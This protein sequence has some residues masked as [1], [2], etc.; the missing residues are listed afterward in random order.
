MSKKLTAAGYDPTNIE[1][2]ARVLAKARGLMG[3]S[4]KRA[5]D[6][7]EDDDEDAW[8]EEGDDSMEVDGAEQTRAVKR[9]KKTSIVP[10][11]TRTPRTNRQLAG[12]GSTAE[13]VKATK[14]KD[15]DRR[16]PNRQAKVRSPVF[17]PIDLAL[18]SHATG[19][20]RRSPH[21]HQDAQVSL[22]RFVPYLSNISQHIADNFLQEKEET[23][24]PIDVNRCRPFLY[25]IRAHPPRPFSDLFSSFPVVLLPIYSRCTIIIPEHH[26]SLVVESDVFCCA[27]RRGRYSRPVRK[28]HD[29]VTKIRLQLCTRILVRQRTKHP[30]ISFFTSWLTRQSP[31]EQ[32]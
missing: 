18:T 23:E 29:M 21:F 27:R 14:L 26:S 16:E 25:C 9:A 2:R 6:D 13:A 28:F 22:C 1:E 10:R 17:F 20:R 19:W 7:M 24:R 5:V 32:Q 31:L 8:A 12:L 30:N 11:G 3:E 4:R 15:L